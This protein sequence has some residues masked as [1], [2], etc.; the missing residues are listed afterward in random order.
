MALFQINPMLGYFF[1]TSIRRALPSS[2]VDNN[3]IKRFNGS[4]LLY[5]AQSETETRICKQHGWQLKPTASVKC[6]K[7]VVISL[8]S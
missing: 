4:I 7:P 3:V 2:Q 8:H 1:E 6:D 5:D